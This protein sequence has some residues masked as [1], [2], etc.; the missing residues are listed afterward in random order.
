MD[1]TA[2]GKNKK[3]LNPEEKLQQTLERDIKVRHLVEH[4]KHQANAASIAKW[5]AALTLKDDIANRNRADKQIKTDSQ[6][7]KTITTNSRRE[8]L[9]Q[10]YKDDE[11]KYE[12]ELNDRGLSFR[13][14]RL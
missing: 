8:R 5:E 10:L 2:K 12:Q 3:T 11:M 9:K 6:A 14:D 13:R 1:Y 7:V 4:A